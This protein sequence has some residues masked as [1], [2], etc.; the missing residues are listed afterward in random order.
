MK[1][2]NIEEFYLY[3]ELVVCM[4]IDQEVANLNF[5]IVLT[6]QICGE[7]AFLQTVYDCSG[8]VPLNFL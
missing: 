4:Y 2:A 5:D 3:V 8:F 6:S 1:C 7:S